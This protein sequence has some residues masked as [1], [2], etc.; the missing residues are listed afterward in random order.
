MG[1]VWEGTSP[2]WAGAPP[3]HGPKAP[4]VWGGGTSTLLGGQVSPSWPPP[5]PSRWDLEGAGPLSPSPIYSGGFGPAMNMSFHLSWRSPTPLPPRLS[6]CLAKPCWSATLLHHHHAIVLLL[7]GGFL[8]LSLLLAGS[9]RGRRHRSVRVLNAEVPS[10]RRLDH[11]EYDSIN[12][13]LLNASAR[14]LQG[15]VDALLPSRC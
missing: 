15:Y 9:R 12:P 8:N 6:Q 4:R 5:L 3:H 1:Q 11:D 2:R 10:V 7:D 14:D 13:V